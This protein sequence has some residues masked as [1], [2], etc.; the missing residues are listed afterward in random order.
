MLCFLIVL[1]V[2]FLCE[3]HALRELPTAALSCI[4]HVVVILSKCCGIMVWMRG[5]VA[6]LLDF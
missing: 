6:L 4:D 1:F 3:L 2:G 5:K